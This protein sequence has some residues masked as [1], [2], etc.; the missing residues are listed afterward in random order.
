MIDV[1][2]GICKM[3][4]LKKTKNKKNKRQ[5]RKKSQ[6]WK[7]VLVLVRDI[8]NALHLIDNSIYRFDYKSK[9]SITFGKR[10]EDFGNILDEFRNC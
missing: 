10:S 5:R 7:R 3:L 8:K 2:R 6:I 1:R 9:T 4:Y